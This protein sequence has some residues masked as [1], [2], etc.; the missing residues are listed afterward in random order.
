MGGLRM[1]PEKVT[2]AAPSSPRQ[3]D[4]GPV[5]QAEGQGVYAAEVRQTPAHSPA[6][7]ESLWLSR[8]PAPEKL[9][10]PLVADSAS[11]TRPDSDLGLRLG[12]AG[13]VR[14]T[15]GLD[16]GGP[17]F[18]KPLLD[19]PTLQEL[20]GL[21]EEIARC[22]DRLAWSV[23]A[24]EADQGRLNALRERQRGMLLDLGPTLATAR[25][26]LEA[27]G[28]PAAHLDY[29][30]TEH[31]VIKLAHLA[32]AWVQATGQ[33]LSMLEKSHLSTLCHLAGVKSSEE[34]KAILAN[35]QNLP[36]PLLNHPYQMLDLD[37]LDAA[38]LAKAVAW[39]Q[40]LY[41][42]TGYLPAHREDLPYLAGAQPAE[43]EQ[44]K[45]FILRLQREAG[46]R[47]ATGGRPSYTLKQVV[48]PPLTNGS[49]VGS[50]SEDELI[51]GAKLFR[52]YTQADLRPYDYE[53]AA[54]LS[55]GSER[56]KNLLGA[57]L[58][59]SQR[60]D[61]PADTKVLCD[62][63]LQGEEF[64]LS[65]LQILDAID[66]ANGRVGRKLASNEVLALLDSLRAG[67]TLDELV[68]DDV[69]VS[70]RQHGA[71]VLLKDIFVLRH[72]LAQNTPPS[73]D[74]LVDA[75][76]KNLR[77]GAASMHFTASYDEDFVAQ[78]DKLTL[79]EIYKV[80]LLT[81]TLKSPDTMKHLADLVQEDLATNWSELGGVVELD[82]EA[83]AE[84]HSVR[85]IRTYDGN[86][87]Y[88]H[89]PRD[90]MNPLLALSEFHFHAANVSNREVAGPSAGPDFPAAN[91]DLA[92]AWA[93]CQDGVVITLLEP[94]VVDV[95]FYTAAGTVVDLGTFE[96]P[97]GTRPGG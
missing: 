87:A 53:A 13:S 19:D 35:L 92:A 68:P 83:G 63:V 48:S 50:V 11:P 16:V 69:V 7:Q 66:T 54:R 51:S 22:E 23:E 77:P 96:L 61:S 80:W 82:H 65:D 8:G 56:D 14:R 81:V 93:Y 57:L 84:F 75:I 30:K 44:G 90:S 74:W 37:S 64:G 33:H 60:Q 59:R 58:M 5:G 10:R 62:I 20:D 15:P 85:P 17:A 3:V 70:M 72:Y 42:A 55:R 28:F 9:I 89:Q 40:T 21:D 47:L 78:S 36:A 43:L 73:R 67:S 1:A 79:A 49:A 26:G 41:E 34:L 38:G 91:G 31:S 25:R 52:Q 12:R 39:A 88:G 46:L 4:A 86:H 97:P 45:Q 6:P 27:Q 76:R 94:G 29:L 18:T 32:P 71:S 2:G 95:D 24:P